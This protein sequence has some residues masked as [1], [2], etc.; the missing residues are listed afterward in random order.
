MTGPRLCRYTREH[1][2]LRE[3]RRRICELMKAPAVVILL[4]VAILALIWRAL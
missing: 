4:P 3:E 2:R 1:E